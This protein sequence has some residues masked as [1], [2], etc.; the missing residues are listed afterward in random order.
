MI[1]RLFLAL[2]LAL[3]LAAQ[4]TDRYALVFLRPSPDRKPLPKEEGEKIQA[5]H[6]AHIR[7]MADSG[8]LVGAGPFGDTPPTI[9]G[10][11]IFKSSVEEARRLAN[12]DPTV[13]AGRNL[14]DIYS[15]QGPKGIGEEYVKL[16]KAD[17]KTPEDMSVHPFLMFLRGPNFSRVQEFVPAHLEHLQRLRSSGK[18]AA[19][20]PI[21][22]GD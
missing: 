13:K 19:A 15:W 6:M 10:V 18:L 9:S 20:G 7:S 22:Q 1:R 3:P 14:V 12:D 16:H 4:P 11:F 21:V 5:A 2:A 17:A 8:A